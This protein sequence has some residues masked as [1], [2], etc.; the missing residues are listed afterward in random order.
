MTT[1][2]G[3]SRGKM[4]KNKFPFTETETW[5]LFELV[6]LFSPV[7]AEMHLPISCT[8][9]MACWLHEPSLLSQ[10]RSEKCGSSR[11]PDTARSCCLPDTPCSVAVK[12][13][14]SIQWTVT[15]HD[16]DLPLSIKVAPSGRLPP[17]PRWPTGSLTAG[18]GALFNPLVP[19]VPK[20]WDTYFDGK[21][22]NNSGT[23]GLT[24]SV[25]W[26]PCCLA[27]LLRQAETCKP[28][29][30]THTD[31][32][33]VMSDIRVTAIPSSSSSSSSYYYY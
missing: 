14:K 19:S 12:L 20:K 15:S 5:R 26:C 18:I 10:W 28:R 1:T 7:T 11:V 13:S 29:S 33:F 4:P 16:I 32:W 25:L 21:S 8:S 9:S 30:S 31:T 23:N 2:A 17:D 24:V 6:S 22:W 27:A 3:Q